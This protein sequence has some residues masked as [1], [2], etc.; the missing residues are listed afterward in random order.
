MGLSVAAGAGA[1]VAGWVPRGGLGRGVAAD[2]E[3][4]GGV[5]ASAVAA[6]GSAE[7][8]LG[9]GTVVAAVSVAVAVAVAGAVTLA[10]AER[11]GPAPAVTRADG[12]IMK[13]A[14]TASSAR[15]KMPA[16]AASTRG[17]R[18]RAAG[19]ARLTTGEFVLA[20]AEA[21]GLLGEVDAAGDGVAGRCVCCGSGV[22]RV[23]ATIGMEGCETARPG[24]EET[25]ADAGFGSLMLSTER[26]R[27]T[28]W[29]EDAGANG[30]SAD[31]RSPAVW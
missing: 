24:A 4:R 14:A 17:T 31:A 25:T 5:A 16:A 19:S 6:L 2:A 28:T 10:F 26:A 8:R 22:R 9:V 27:A 1:E 23:S 18:E 29:C 11:P 13:V 21:E 7:G 15:T 3:A 20:C 30:S 12:R